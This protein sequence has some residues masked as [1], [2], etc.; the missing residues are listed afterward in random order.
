MPLSICYKI[1]KIISSYLEQ[2]TACIFVSIYTRMHE[3]EREHMREYVCVNP[4]YEK[5][6]DCHF[7]SFY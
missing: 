1:D 6:N 2:K 7:L 5:K 4:L 3:K